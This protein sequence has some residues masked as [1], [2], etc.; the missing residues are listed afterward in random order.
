MSEAEARSTLW[1]AQALL[2][3]FYLLLPERLLDVVVR[4]LD[5]LPRWVSIRASIGLAAS[6]LPSVRLR[7]GLLHQQGQSHRRALAGT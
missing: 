6:P 3:P 2:P 7:S 1:C 5:G 4:S